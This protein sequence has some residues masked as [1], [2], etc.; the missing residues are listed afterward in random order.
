[1][2]MDS[3]F[4]AS[5]DAPLAARFSQLW[6]AE[7]PAPDVFAFLSSYPDVEAGDRLNVLFVDQAERW[8]RGQPLPLRIYLSAF[9]EI[10]T[11]GEMVRALVDRER[12]ERRRSAGRLNENAVD[13]IG[14]LDLRSENAAHRSRI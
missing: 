11:R 6:A 14:H 8:K 2:A 9:P 3:S 12:E 4:L 7:A 5:T 10:A 13:R 1:M